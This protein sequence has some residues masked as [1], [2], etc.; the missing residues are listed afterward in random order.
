MNTA[1]YHS[2]IYQGLLAAV[3]RSFRSAIGATAAHRDK[4]IHRG[5]LVTADFDADPHWSCGQAM[6]RRDI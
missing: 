5:Y 6:Y 3:V 4:P 1:A 2:E